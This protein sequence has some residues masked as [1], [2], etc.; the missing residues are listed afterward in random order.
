MPTRIV[1]PTASEVTV[2][3]AT[4]A[5]TR[6]LRSLWEVLGAAQ[7]RG[8]SDTSP[9]RTARGGNGGAAVWAAATDASASA[10][11]E[12]FASQA[13]LQTAGHETVLRLAAMKRPLGSRGFVAGPFPLQLEGAVAPRA[14][15]CHVVTRSQGQRDLRGTHHVKNARGDHGV[16]RASGDG[17][18]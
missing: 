18:T 11:A 14:T 10:S 9:S 17:T 16:D 3:S 13:L 4:R 6:R 7:R 15:I 2:T 12:S 5:R 8:R 1:S